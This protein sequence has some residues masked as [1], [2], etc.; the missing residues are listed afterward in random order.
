MKQ[1]ILANN[2]QIPNN[3]YAHDS[4]EEIEQIPNPDN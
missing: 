2:E 3:N 1:M 4:V